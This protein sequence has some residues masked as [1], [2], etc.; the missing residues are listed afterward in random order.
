VKVGIRWKNW[1]ER[2]AGQEKETIHRKFREIEA[3]YKKREH[4]SKLGEEERGNGN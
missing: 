1:R 3:A 2:K 4:Q